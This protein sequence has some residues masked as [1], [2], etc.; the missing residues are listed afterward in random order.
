MSTH[1]RRVILIG[2]FILFITAAGFALFGGS[3]VEILQR[4]H[5]G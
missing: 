2:L 5:A 4:M 1:S 3:L